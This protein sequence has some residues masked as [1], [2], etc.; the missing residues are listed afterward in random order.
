MPARRYRYTWDD[1]AWMDADHM[2][3]WGAFEPDAK[4]I[5]DF[6]DDDLPKLAFEM[7]DAGDRFSVFYTLPSHRH[8]APDPIRS[9]VHLDRCRC[10]FGGTRAYFIAPC[11]SRR[12]LRLAVLEDGLR[13][14]TCG[15]ITWKS[16]REHELHRLI[17]KANKIADRLGCDDWMETPSRRPLHMRQATFEKLKRERAAIAGQ[18]NQHL[19]RT[20]RGVVQRALNAAIISVQVEDLR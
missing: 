2:A 14:G 6:N 10:R 3:S 13:C 18:I 11:C 7:T 5:I 12:T 19:L 20:R 9:T 8:E 17:R 4:H 1:I 15:S 16:R